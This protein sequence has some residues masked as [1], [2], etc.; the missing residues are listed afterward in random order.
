MFTPRPTKANERH[1]LQ[2]LNIYDYLAV[3]ENLPGNLTIGTMVAKITAKIA[4]GGVFPR[5]LPS[6][7]IKGTN[8]MQFR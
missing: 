1:V 7:T 3:N 2:K 4:K 6:Q 8:S 5:S